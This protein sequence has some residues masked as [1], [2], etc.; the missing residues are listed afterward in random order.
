MTRC[1]D[2]DCEIRVQPEDVGCAVLCFECSV[3][4]AKDEMAVA[5]WASNPLAF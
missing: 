1:I 5:T 2:C 3:E 4:R